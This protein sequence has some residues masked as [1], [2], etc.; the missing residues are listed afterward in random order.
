MLASTTIFFVDRY[1]KEWTYLT[2]MPWETERRDQLLY[3]LVQN[4]IPFTVVH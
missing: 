2:F 3:E 4:A 1:V